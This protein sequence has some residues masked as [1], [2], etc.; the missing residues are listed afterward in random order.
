M[1]RT[2]TA[3]GWR[4]YLLLLLL[5]LPLYAFSAAQTPDDLAAMT[6][7]EVRQQLHHMLAE[8]QQPQLTATPFSF[9]AARS[10]LRQQIARLREHWPQ[11][12]ERL[13]DI[14]ARIIDSSR[15]DSGFTLLLYTLFAVTL[16]YLIERLLSIPI[17]RM[18]QRARHQQFGSWFESL[19]V[20]L[21]GIGIGLIRLALF[22]VALSL[23]FLSSG[24]DHA[25]GNYFSV[26]MNT[27]VL[28]RL[29]AMISSW[30]LAPSTDA[31]ST[32]RLVPLPP[33]QARS[34][35]RTILAFAS[36]YLLGRA[37]GALLRQSTY[38]SELVTAYSVVVGTLLTLAILMLIWAQRRPLEQL[39]SRG[40]TPT[41]PAGS[42]LQQ[43]WP[44]LLSAW[45][46]LLWTLWSFHRLAGNDTLADKVGLSWWVTLLFPLADRLLARLIHQLTELPWFQ[47]RSFA[48]RGQAMHTVLQSG[49]RIIMVSV[50]LLSLAEAWGLGTV[51][52]LREAGGERLMSVV[53]DTLLILLLAYFAWQLIVS[54]IE[55]HLPEP[56][57]DNGEGASL[58]GEGG[59]AGGT[60]TET[61]LPL[62]RSMLLALLV[63]TTL[64]SVLSA[65][66][67]E[68]GPLIA[69]AGVVGIAIG[70]GAQK[71]V[72]DVISG[73]FFLVDDAFRRGEYIETGD[74]RGTVEKISLRS[75][76]LRHHLGAVQTV[77]YGS[78]STIK[79]LSRDWVTMKLEIRLPYETDIEKVRKIVKK[80][81][82][83]LQQDPELGPNLLLPLKSQGVARVE[84]SA[85]IVRMKFTA[86]PGE[87]WVLRRE[88]YRQVRDALQEAGITFA[89]PE[90]RI[91]M[92]EGG[93]EAGE[94]GAAVDPGAVEQAVA[95]RLRSRARSQADTKPPEDTP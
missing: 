84:E 61:L 47:S 82:Q 77:P 3:Q 34:L 78:I 92:P 16:A 86:K 28:I 93:A 90:V 52:L 89:H 33:Q 29:V 71:L 53:V 31:N 43:S 49:V 40:Q 83:N 67:I 30:I 59:G 69:G 23:L 17:H 62:L 70:F 15:F 72:Q 54:C 8:Q 1:T 45:L 39:L 37:L 81:G 12:D 36:V 68:I 55:R 87:Q 74:L 20:Q 32:I 42:L 27:A 18:G 57:E 65:I 76:Q 9:D 38:P 58:E 25:A 21:V 95:G 46:L 22:Y 51:E 4:H 80:V 64:L 11:A 19:C 2:P 41:T 5:A 7:K 60:R 73:V 79:N 13:A 10:Q 26:I 56:P 44:W 66:G 14:G 50:A 24:E 85:L 63:I 48:Q 91:R 94:A 35:H 6:D 88:A 75:M